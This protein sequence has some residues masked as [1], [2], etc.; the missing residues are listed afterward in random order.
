RADLFVY[1]H[2]DW[3]REYLGAM[4]S[5]SKELNA[6]RREDWVGEWSLGA[7]DRFVPCNYQGGAGVPDLI[8]HDGD[9]LGMIR[10]TPALVLDRV[11][12]RWVHNYRYGRNW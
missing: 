10:A 5:N 1:N 11:Y 8:V 9:W 6:T 3:G 12:H 2:E 4:V 7:D